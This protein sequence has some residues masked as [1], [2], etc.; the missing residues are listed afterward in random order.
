MA[1]LIKNIRHIYQ[2]DNE[3]PSF[4]RGKEMSEMKIIEDAFILIENECIKDFGPMS[5]CPN[6]ADETIDAAGGSIL[7]AFCDSH[8]HLVYAAPREQEFVYRIQG[9]SYQ[10]IAAKGGGILNSARK[11]QECSEEKLFEDA[12]ER[13]EAVIRSG[14][15]AIEIKSGYGLTVEAELKMLRVIKKIKEKCPIPVKAS[16]LGA[17]AMPLE[18]R[19]NR[20]GYISLILNKM[21]PKIA[22]EGL[23]DYIDVFCE[24]GFYSVEE[25]DRILEKGSKYGLLPKIHCNQFNSMGGIE[26]AIKYNALSVDH[27]EVLNDTEI[28][29]LQNSN[30]IATLLPSA[31]FFLNDEHFPPARKLVDANVP[32]ALA[33]DYNPGTS[34]SG[35][36]P[37]VLSLACIKLRLLPEEAFNAATINGAFAMGLEKELGSITIGKK[38]NLILT[39]KIP[40]LAFIPYNFGASVVE[41][42]IIN[43]RIF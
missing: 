25:T 34:P 12:C 18:Y 11:L 8:T 1:V 3:I 38:A 32:F 6:R 21:L 22:E 42:M 13:L 30:T 35:N 39:K 43:G 33:S 29:A 10:E 9:M 4:L 16:F 20:E 19:E 24:K 23:A 41:K 28:T 17:H 36:M 31:P 37:F 7:P 2:A 15:G 26:T 27:L 14:T 40:S 5:L